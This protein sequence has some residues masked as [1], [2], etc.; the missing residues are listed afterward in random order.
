M[1]IEKCLQCGEEYDPMYSSHDCKKKEKS[2]NG[3]ED[4][5]FGW[6]SLFILLVSFWTA[7][8]IFN[9]IKDIRT[10]GL[11]DILFNVLWIIFTSVAIVGVLKRKKWGLYCLYALLIIST[12]LVLITTIIDAFAKFWLIFMMATQSNNWI[13]LL[14]ILVLAIILIGVPLLISYLWFRYFRRRRHWFK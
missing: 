5:G 13:S 14:Y 11:V 1:A 8:N 3:E 2:T 4:L 6:G 9:L 7:V 12:L 10:L